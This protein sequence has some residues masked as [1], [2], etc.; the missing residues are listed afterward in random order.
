M[1]KI[2]EYKINLAAEPF[3]NLKYR[4]RTALVLCKDGKG[5]YLLDDGKNFY[6]KGIV[7]LLGGGIDAD[8]SALEGAI[9]EVNEEMG[10]LVSQ[11][12]MAELAEIDVAGVFEGKTYKHK[13]FV[14]FLNSKK[15]DYLA[16]D[17]VSD[18]VA[19][20]EKEYRELIKRYL[21]LRDDNIYNQKGITFSWGDYGKVYGFIH[22]VALKELKARGL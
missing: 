2:Y 19:Y 16:G 1:F 5:N 12:E 4:D 20:S 10:V 8:E 14:Y 15:D 17:D 22:Q 13:V 3:E 11:D 7:R 18:I 6:P 21:E 9:R